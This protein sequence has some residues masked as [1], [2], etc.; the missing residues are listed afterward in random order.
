MSDSFFEELQ[1]EFLQESAFMLEQYEESMLGL[2]NGANPQEDL[3]Q[4]FRVAHSIKGGAAAV[5]FSDLGK[6]AH[7]MED[8]LALLRVNP[9]LVSSQV[10]SCLLRSGDMLKK[11]VVALQTKVD[12]P[13]DTS[14]LREELIQLIQQCGGEAK[15][16]Q[17]PQSSD[18]QTA[19][20]MPCAEAEAPSELMAAAEQAAE[21]AASAQIENSGED[22]TNY[23]L[24]KE[25]EAE[26]GN[27][28]EK[29]LLVPEIALEPPPEVVAQRQAEIENAKSAPPLAAVVTAPTPPQAPAAAAN[30]G[31]AEKKAGGPPAKMNSSIKVDTARLDSVL[32]AVGEIVVLK[33]QLV[34][35]DAVKDSSNPRLA[36][37]VDQLDKLVRELY[38]KTLGIRMTPLKSLFLKI[39]RIVRDVSLQLGKPVDLKL[40]GEE[41]EVERTV[42]ELLGDPLTHL[43]R[44]ALD[45]GIEKPDLRA[46]RKKPATASLTVSAKQSGGSVIIEISDDGG[47]ISREKVLAKAIEKGLVPSH[48]DTNTL[49]D[50]QVFQF[51]FAPGFSTAE[52]VTDLSGR[53]VGLDVVRSNLEKIN[54]KMDIH[55]K[56][57]VGTTFRL[58]IPL[59]TAITDGILVALDGF[60]YI[61]PIHSIREIVRAQ[62]KDYTRITGGGSVVMVREALLPVIDIKKTLGQ[63]TQEKRNKNFLHEADKNTLRSRREETML[64]VIESMYGTMA[65]PVDDVIGQSQVVVKALATGQNIP[66]V[67]GA[68]IMGDGRTVL[69]L[70][71]MALTQKRQP[72]KSSCEKSA[73]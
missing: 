39:Q 31:S 29:E 23:E 3:A 40:I 28:L 46:D 44:N 55:S 45:H 52:K 58:S 68:A 4:I 73:A 70:D 59:S 30:V 62:P 43:V 69:I 60:K 57:G 22:F 38:D 72:E 7:V 61:L 42:F 17:Q 5:G 54:G 35:D 24:L 34:H 48:V 63:I 1:G 50:E 8:L 18:H 26:L 21:H 2:E 67:A 33:N 16:D 53:G 32:D 10:I 51:I 56:A 64:I 9:N 71:P 15:Y 49:P 36:A 6:F 47:G 66:E 25:L 20:E 19:I 65:L 14:A 12:E 27:V 41:T 11:R 13:W 37:I